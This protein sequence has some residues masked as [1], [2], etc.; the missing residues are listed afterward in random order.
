MSHSDL[1][2]SL[3]TAKQTRALDR[4][5]IASGVPGFKLMQR[6]GHAAF[7]RLRQRWPDVRKLTLL[8]GGGNNGGDGFVVAVLAQRLGMQVQLL[9]VGGDDFAARLSGEA[10]QAWEWL[11]TES[12]AWQLY[13]EQPFTGEL[14]IDGLLGTGISG[15]VRD[16]FRTAIKQI[17]RAGLPVVAL[18]IPSGLCSD[19][20]AVLGVAVRADMTVTFI[21][22]KRG[23]LTHEG[24]AFT[25]ELLFDGLRVSDDVY[26]SV[27]V[28]GFITGAD[29][30]SHLLPPRSTTTHK[31]DC[32]HV[33]VI[34][35][36]TG[37]GGAAIM[38][39]QAAGRCGAGLVTVATRAEHLSALLS[40][41]PE[42]MAVGVRSGS[43]L[44]PFIERADVLVVGP[45]LGK[46]A[47][48]EQLLMQALGADKPLVLDADALNLLTLRR[49]F[50]QRNGER[51]VITPHPGE[52]ARLLGCS[53]AGLQ[54]DRFAAVV[55]LQAAFGGVALLKGPGSLSFDGDALHLNPTGNP[56]MAS[57]GMGDVLSG[58]I[59]A[60]I[61]QG[62]SAADATRLGA[63][64]HGAAAD[65]SA[66]LYGTRGMQAT[67]LLA[68]LRLLVNGL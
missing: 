2:A 13:N 15:E 24:P 67:D 57:G 42:A 43:E 53:V 50:G 7:D 6:A 66:A 28:A 55:E 23:L 64:L 25:G 34:G 26:E 38:A 29:D 60:L 22:V 3:Y 49:E 59:G 17:N 18:D 9:C 16:P 63:W 37:M 31:G 8:C 58:V 48:G 39:A 12:V 10:L 21:G 51:W 56:G 19:T 47:W 65:R 62:L 32:G 33:L 46:N 4:T 27:D 20:G 5:A 61:A 35:G 44:E 36:D 52:A 1:P 11:Q 41:Y 54:A 68:Q 30:L 40:R 45:G 14:I